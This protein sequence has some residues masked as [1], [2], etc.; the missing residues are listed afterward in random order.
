MS[1]L[2]GCPFI[3]S[4]LAARMGHNHVCRWRT[5]VLHPHRQGGVPEEAS[6]DRLGKPLD[7]VAAMCVHAIDIYERRIIV[8]EIAK[9]KIGDALPEVTTLR[10]DPVPRVRAAAGRAVAVLTAAGS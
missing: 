7:L 8:K 1:Y 2:V 6:M 3:A 9:R 5:S 4:Q 10:E